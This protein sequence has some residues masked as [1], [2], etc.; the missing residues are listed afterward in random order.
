M[1][2]NSSLSCMISYTACCMC[3]NTLY[4]QEHMMTSSYTD[5]YDTC[6]AWSISRC[7]I[8]TSFAGQTLTLSNPHHCLM[9]NMPRISCGVNWVTDNV[10]W[11]VWHLNRLVLCI[12]YY[13]T[14]RFVNCYNNCFN[15]CL[16]IRIGDVVDSSTTMHAV[17]QWRLSLATQPS[18]GYPHGFT[19]NCIETCNARARMYWQPY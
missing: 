14:C 7:Q 16:L 8:L 4:N 9:P 18:A 6:Y 11:R 2:C 13:Q 5:N 1:A 17:W 19:I 15:N 10:A 12:C 3:L